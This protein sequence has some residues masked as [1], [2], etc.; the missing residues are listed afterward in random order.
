[1]ATGIYVTSGS[2]AT[3]LLPSAG[4]QSRRRVGTGGN[5]TVAGTRRRRQRASMIITVIFAAIK[6]HFFII[7]TARKH[8]AG[9]NILGRQKRNGREYVRYRMSFATVIRCRYVSCRAAFQPPRQAVVFAGI[10]HGADRRRW[11]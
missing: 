4:A 5:V 11:L 6:C 3:I 2:I 10:R 9:A 1:M 7:V 8:T